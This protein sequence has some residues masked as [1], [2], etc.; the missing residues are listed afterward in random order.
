MKKN[1]KG[2]IATLAIAVSVSGVL[3]SMNSLNSKADAPSPKGAKIEN[4]FNYKGLNSTKILEKLCAKAKANMVPDVNTDVSEEL[5]PEVAPE[6]TIDPN[7]GEVGPEDGLVDEDA[8]VEVEDDSDVIVEDIAIT[9]DED[10]LDSEEPVVLTEEPIDNVVVEDETEEAELSVE[11]E[12][13]AEVKNGIVKEND[14]FV[15]YIDSVV[16]TSFTGLVAQKGKFW[17]VESGYVNRE[18]KGIKKLYGFKMFIKNGKVLTTYSGLEK[19]DDNWIYISNGIFDKNARGNARNSSGKWFVKKGKVRKDF[20]GLIAI[21]EGDIYYFK[22]GRIA[23]EVSGLKYNKDKTKRFYVKNG[24]VNRK[25]TG[26]KKFGE[27]KY[28][29][30]N[31]KWNDKYTGIFIQNTNEK[32]EILNPVKKQKR[33]YVVNGILKQN[34]TTIMKQGLKYVGNPYVYGGTSLTNGIDCSAFTQQIYAKAGVSIPRTSREQYS[35]AKKITKEQAEPG[36]L[37]FYKNESG[38]VSHVAIY[39]GHDM[40][41]H[42]SNPQDGIKINRYDYRTAYFGRLL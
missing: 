3:M 28:L 20:N 11:D 7:V 1:V 22:R 34:N 18:F 42:A 9:E 17:Y 4:R 16:Q 19:D 27:K 31:G 6:V 5:N 38:T 33:C 24:K 23:T 13:P 41:V 2:I 30:Q 29:I 15:Y 8:Y 35:E 37:V 26:I 40:I 12:Q 14:K 25:F 36:D 39:L 32:S 10:I 21:K